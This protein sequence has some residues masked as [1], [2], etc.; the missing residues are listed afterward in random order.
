MAPSRPPALLP[1]A[2]PTTAPATVLKSR[3]LAKADDEI[4]AVASNATPIIFL[5]NMVFPL[6]AAR[7][8]MIR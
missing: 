6:A 3:S 5:L 1:I 4:A 7:I 8:E 2:A